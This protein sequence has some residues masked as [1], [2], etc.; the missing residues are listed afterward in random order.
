MQ[1]GEAFNVLIESGHTLALLRGA[2]SGSAA[3]LT[4]NNSV[5]NNARPPKSWS[6]RCG[7]PMAAIPGLQNHTIG[8]FTTRTAGGRSS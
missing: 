3:T 2:A 1:V 7:I 5:S 4:I 8:S 6:R